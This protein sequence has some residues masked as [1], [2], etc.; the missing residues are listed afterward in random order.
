[1]HACCGPLVCSAC[2]SGRG[3]E[4]RNLQQGAG[5]GAGAGLARNV[6][7]CAPA[8]RARGGGVL[9]GAGAADGE[10]GGGQDV[11][12]EGAADRGSDGEDREG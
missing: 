4:Q 3:A 1:M 9:R 11:A 5:G 10:W 12:G 2:V 6:G 8:G 7:V